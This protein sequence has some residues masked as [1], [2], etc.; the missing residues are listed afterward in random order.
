[1]CIFQS[2]QVINLRFWHKNGKSELPT[3]LPDLSP[4]DYHVWGTML[5]R[6]QKYMAKPTNIAAEDCLAIYMEWFA[7]GVNW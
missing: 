6:Y 3:N 2:E 4:L 1:M 5:E 7:T